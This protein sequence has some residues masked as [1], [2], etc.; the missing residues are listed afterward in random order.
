MYAAKFDIFL[1]DQISLTKFLKIRIS[2]YSSN[3]FDNKKTIKISNHHMQRKKCENK[4]T[5]K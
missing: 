2:S 3:Q 5:N 4:T 1:L